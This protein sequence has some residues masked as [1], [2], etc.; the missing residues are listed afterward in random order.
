MVV[1]TM[2]TAKKCTNYLREHK[3]GCNTFIALDKVEQD[4]GRVEQKFEAPEGV[5]R[6]VDL[7]VPKDKKYLTAF[8]NIL[9][10]TLV[11]NDLEQATRI[12]YSGKRYRVVTLKGELID[13]SGTMSGGGTKIMKGALSSS[14]PDGDD[15]IKIN[16]GELEN[17]ER[18]LKDIEHRLEEDRKKRKKLESEGQQEGK[19]INDIEIYIK[20]AVMGTKELKDNIKR[21]TEQLPSLEAAIE[22]TERDTEEL[23]LLQQRKMQEEKSLE[24]ATQKSKDIQEQI[25]DLTTQMMDAGGNQVHD[26]KLK[27]EELTKS[28]DALQQ[29]ITKI[30][31]GIEAAKKKIEKSRKEGKESEKAIETS[32]EKLEQ[33]K[34]EF[35]EIEEAASKVM[36]A[37]RAAQAALTEKEKELKTIQKDYEGKKKDR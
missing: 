14:M 8:Y 4:R 22:P 37:Y 20:K 30:T 9:R 18:E 6:L 7:L 10:D 33:F 16:P 24:T 21:I 25:D 5:P 12:A 1:D 29:E 32:L 31:V 26:Q 17:L 28:L 11:A 27:L 13:I 2:E 23:K 36:V 35:K 34:V 3:L 15:E 19:I